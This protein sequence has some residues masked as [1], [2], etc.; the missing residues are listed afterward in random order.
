MRSAGVLPPLDTC[1]T[2][3]GFVTALF[4]VFIRDIPRVE[5]AVVVILLANVTP[6]VTLAL[7]SEGAEERELSIYKFVSI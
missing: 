6:K 2:I 4:A 1:E 5:G 3:Q 7:V